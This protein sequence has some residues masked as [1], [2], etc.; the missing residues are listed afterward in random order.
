[1][2]PALG[3]FGAGGSDTGRTHDAARVMS[4]FED[5]SLSR[6][7]PENPMTVLIAFGGG[8]A[9]YLLAIYTWPALRGFVL[10]AEQELI[11]VKARLA[12]LEAKVRAAFGHDE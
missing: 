11:A 6:A 3:S 2:Q 7:N 5:E 10:G 8:A 9:G 1:L 12:E 4:S